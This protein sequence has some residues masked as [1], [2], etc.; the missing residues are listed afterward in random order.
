MGDYSIK[1]VEKNGMRYYQV[2]ECNEI[3]GTYP[4][5]T[6]I[7]GN[8]SDKSG[9]EKWKKRVGEA[10]AKRISELS[11]NRGTIM[12]RLIELYKPLKGS[13]AE[14]LEQLKQIAAD[15][16]EVNQFND[17]EMG[18]IWREAGWTMF[19]KFYLSSSKYFDRVAEVIEA[20]T[21]LWSKIGYAGT[22]DNI[23]KMVDDRT[24]VI[25]YKNSRRPKR[26]EW[27]QDYFIQ[28][29]AYF[30]AHWE[31]SG[32]KPDGVE[33]WI[34]NEEENIPQTFSLTA[35]DVKY[36]FTEFI[37]RLKQFKQLYNE[38]AEN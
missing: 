6:T 2:S 20:E 28:G 29:S 30:I 17:H 35:E 25:D 33:I 27:V 12:H 8:T 23:S 18:Q 3:I 11:M 1:R 34:A 4:S 24:L 15:D 14:K 22:V 13:K 10:E 7:L 26:E 9:L 38:P 16:D 37:K 19:M 32:V 36:Y 21:F 31:R 5:I